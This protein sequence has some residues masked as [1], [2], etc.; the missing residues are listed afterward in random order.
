MPPADPYGMRTRENKGVPVQRHLAG[1]TGNGAN[2]A[3]IAH[4]G[5]LFQIRR[6]NTAKRQYLLSIGY[7][8]YR[9]IH[10]THTTYSKSKF[11]K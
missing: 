10:K 2:R 11:V 4:F 7:S 1:I 9:H 5:R 3:G 8:K 6:R